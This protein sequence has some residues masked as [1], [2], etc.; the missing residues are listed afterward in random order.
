MAHIAPLFRAGADACVRIKSGTGLPRG[1]TGNTSFFTATF[2]VGSSHPVT[3]FGTAA[4]AQ[5]GG[6][7]LSIRCMLSVTQMQ[8]AGTYLR[9]QLLTS[10][11]TSRELF[12]I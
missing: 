12:E 5:G 11:R 3:F 8:L 7:V 10:Y 9:P 2:S 1:A 6:F 4:I